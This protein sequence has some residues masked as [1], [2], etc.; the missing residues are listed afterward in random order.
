M[1]CLW[2]NLCVLWALIYS[3]LLWVVCFVFALCYGSCGLCSWFWF[4]F[5]IFGVFLHSLLCI[6][7]SYVLLLFFVFCIG[8]NLLVLNSYVLFDMRYGLGSACY[9]LSVMSS[10][11]CVSSLF[12]EVLCN[13]FCSVYCLIYYLL[14]VICS[15]MYHLVCYCVIY[16]ICYLLCVTLLFICFAFL[17]CFVTCVLYDL[18]VFRI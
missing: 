4:V 12:F 17:L 8:F 10:L 13:L 9:V 6:L 2:F 5:Y 1:L 14:S 7:M 18:A 15:V 16:V 11:L 3:F